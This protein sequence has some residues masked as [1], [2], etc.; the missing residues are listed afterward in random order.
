MKRKFLRLIGLLLV[1]TLVVGC[2]YSGTEARI[3]SGSVD[4]GQEMLH[5]A[6]CE[7]RTE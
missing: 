6:I 1:L 3:Q 2:G 5:G 4:S 7:F